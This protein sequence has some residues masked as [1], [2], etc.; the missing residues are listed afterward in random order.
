MVRSVAVVAGLFYV[1]GF[2]TTNSYLYKLGVSDFSL[3]RTR[4][5]LTGVLTLAPLALALV[6]GIYAA[7]DLSIYGGERGLSKHAT[8]W[9]LA[10]V[11]VPF[12]LYFLLFAVVAE[13]DVVTAARDAALL[14]L[15]CALVVLALLSSLW[16]YR[17]SQRRPLSHLIYRR[18]DV[19]YER[20]NARFGVPTTVVETMTFG[21]GGV[22]LI[23]AYIGIFGYHFYPAIP[24]Q[25][26]GGRP[27]VVQLLIAADAVPDARQLG[28]DVSEEAPLSPPLE[29][30]W[31][32]EESYV[33]RLPESRQQTVVQLA[34]GLVDGVVSGAALPSPRDSAGA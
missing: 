25:I 20:F 15:I 34:Q 13:N 23:L 22:L 12:M 30:L 18:H 33:V 24:E 28:L 27:R 21:V 6:W 16:L 26:G 32:G 14:S 8:L 1:L 4:F 11:T 29:L 19:P 9:M 3:L 2:L 31:E 7:L 17:T 10:D 5:I